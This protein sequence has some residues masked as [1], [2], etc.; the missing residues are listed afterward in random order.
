VPDAGAG[1]RRFGTL[2]AS[3][4]LFALATLTVADPDL[5][6]HLRF[7]HDILATRAVAAVDPY[8]FTQDRT[9]INHEWLSEAL[10]AAAFAAGG[11]AGVALLK[12]T[13]VFSTLHIVW[14]S[15]SSAAAAAR[16]TAIGL[17][18]LGAG[19]VLAPMRPQ[20][21]SMLLFAVLCR[22]LSGPS[23]SAKLG[24]PVLFGVW[25]NLHGGWIVGLAVIVV[26]AAVALV[27]RRESAMRW[28]AVAAASAAATLATPYGTTLWRFLWDTV[29]F[30][31]DI[32][33]WQPLTALPMMNWLPA[34]AVAAIAL[35]LI[36]DRAVTYRL[37]I[38]AALALLAAC[39]LG[40]SRIGPIFVIC[41]GV[42]L[43]PALARR[44]PARSPRGDTAAGRRTVGGLGVA[45][46][47]TATIV[48]SHSLAHIP[49]PASWSPPREAA[50]RLFGTSGRLV[51]FFDW[52][53][54]AIWHF[55]PRLRVS[56]DGRRETVYSERRLAEHDA[57]VAG[58]NDGFAT[59]ADWQ[60]E[61]IWL[62][63]RTV[64]TKNWLAAHGYRIDH[65]DAASFIAVR[66]DLPALGAPAAAATVSGPR[67]FPD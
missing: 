37:E 46:V 38:G 13:L 43:A 2:G 11:V 67:Y 59:L 5:W 42:L 61:Y 12:G 3:A 36:A 20:L 32:T 66:S 65:E 58:T 35:W 19:P 7:G 56:M 34:A 57:I 40:V 4:L 53:E 26:W 50:Q 17:V 29:G 45:A 62:P 63:A 16:L 49:V 22:I 14:R 31:R 60:A 55:G 23:R 47:T 10:M 41:A 15:L 54:Y 8:S 39:A 44:W 1:A 24:L 18:V 6:G 33:E 27:A 64:A 25:A 9:W 30:T 28:A 51:T 52:G 48:L 21:F